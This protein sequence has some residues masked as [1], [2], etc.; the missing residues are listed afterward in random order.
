[1]KKKRKK[2]DKIKRLDRKIPGRRI[3]I[4]CDDGEHE[5]EEV[6]TCY[7]KLRFLPKRDKNPDD[8]D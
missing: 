7:D 3:L 5:W 6:R 2:Q 8:D 1:M 4:P